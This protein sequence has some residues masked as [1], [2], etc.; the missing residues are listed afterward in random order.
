[1]ERFTERRENL[2]KLLAY[3]DKDLI[4]VVTGL[5]RSGK[6]VLLQL[7]MRQLLEIGIKAGMACILK[8]STKPAP[9]GDAEILWPQGKDCSK[10]PGAATGGR[11][12]KNIDLQMVTSRYKSGKKWNPGFPLPKWSQ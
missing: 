2:D 1:M 7:F 11:R 9:G 8:S 5:R 3:R 4:K 6:S 10:A 12:P